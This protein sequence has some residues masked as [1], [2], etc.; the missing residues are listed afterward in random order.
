MTPPRGPVLRGCIAGNVAQK[1]LLSTA[2]HALHHLELSASADRN[3]PKWSRQEA[4]S[5]VE[6]AIF[7]DNAPLTAA[8]RAA[9]ATSGGL[10]TELKKIL[11][12]AQG[13]EA[14]GGPSATGGQSVR[15]ERFG[16]RKITLLVSK[17]HKLFALDA[18]GKGEVLWS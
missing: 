7:V 10:V 9:G 14:P 8:Q 15:A 2:D 11:A 12:K 17:A 5:S 18:A 4:L 1:C 6:Q 13:G 3:T 16:F